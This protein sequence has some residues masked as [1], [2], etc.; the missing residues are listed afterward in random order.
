MEGHT[1]TE[2]GL[3]WRWPLDHVLMAEPTVRSHWQPGTHRWARW[4]RVQHVREGG[5]EGVR[6]GGREGGREKGRV[7]INGSISWNQGGR[8]G[9]G[10]GG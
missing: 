7:L 3:W 5:R 10:E 4:P 6:E 8:E 2:S 9:E 1:G